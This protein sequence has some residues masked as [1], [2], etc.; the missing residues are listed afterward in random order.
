MSRRQK[1]LLLLVLILAGVVSGRLWTE[2]LR[3]RG[4]LSD[5]TRQLGESRT[6]WETTAA[7]KEALQEEK[8]IVDGALREA[9]LTLA[10]STARAEELGTEIAALEAEITLLRNEGTPDPDERAGEQKTRTQENP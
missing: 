5:L 4:R 9:E 3:D 10:E 8:R 1:A 7:E 2:L 6:A